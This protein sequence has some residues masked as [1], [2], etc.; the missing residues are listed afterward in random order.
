MD[1]LTNWIINN[2]KY[3]ISSEHE[4]YLC[5]DVFI[6]GPQQILD[7]VVVIALMLLA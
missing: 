1:I 7:L 5:L 4:N 6:I 2:K 3:K